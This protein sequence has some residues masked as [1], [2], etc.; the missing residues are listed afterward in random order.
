VTKTT[1]DGPDLA[2]IR[3]EQEGKTFEQFR[4]EVLAGG[5]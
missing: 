4:D 5:R 2:A 3:A 1:T